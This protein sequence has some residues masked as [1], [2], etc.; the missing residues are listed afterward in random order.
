MRARREKEERK[1]QARA[2]REANE[3]LRS[4]GHLGWSYWLTLAAVA[5]AVYTLAVLVTGCNPAALSTLKCKAEAAELLP[6]D[7][8][9]VTVSHA[10]E[11]VE[12]VRRCS[13]DADAGR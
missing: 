13:R 1:A 7:P 5:W 10:I 3:V 9:A 6:D 4:E 2:M 12:A 11:V 8:G